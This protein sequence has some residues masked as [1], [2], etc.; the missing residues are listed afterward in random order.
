[1]KRKIKENSLEVDIGYVEFI[2]ENCLD[3]ETLLDKID[4]DYEEFIGD[5]RN[6]LSAGMLVINIG[7]YAGKISEY[8]RLEYKDFPWSDI[9]GM[10]NIFAHNYL[11]V[12]FVILWNTLNNDVPEIKEFFEDILKKLNETR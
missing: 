6:T 10:R 7:E 5:K 3:A 11:G 1:M 9:I 4:Y 12:N 2:I 8:I